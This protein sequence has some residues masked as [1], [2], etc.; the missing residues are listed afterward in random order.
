MQGVF[1][2]WEAQA[3]AHA[4]RATL[5]VD[6]LVGGTPSDPNVA[7]GWIRSKLAADDDLIRQAV[8]DLMVERGLD[9]ETA[10][11]ELARRKHLNGFKR[12]PV[13]GLYIEGRQLKA[14]LK[15]AANIRWPWQG[16]MQKT[17]TFGAAKKTARHWWPEHIFVIEDRLY[18]GV[19][20]PSGVMQRF[21]VSRHGTGIQLEEYVDEA[22]ITATVETDEDIPEETWAFLWLTAQ[23]QGVGASRSQGFGRFTLTE[24]ERTR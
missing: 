5:V 16:S 8:A 20:R 18:L 3:Y 7:E 22:K 17:K 2:K 21:I 13:H 14:C 12:D 1:A 9:A 24:W 4:F 6:R 11:T 19:E 10:A 23:R 15:E